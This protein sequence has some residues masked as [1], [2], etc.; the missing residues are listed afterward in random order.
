M[1]KTLNIVVIERTY[2]SIIKATYD[3]TTASI[4]LD[5][6]KLKAFPLRLGTGQVCLLLPL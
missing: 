4:L 2:L 6:E 3:K 1:I 5:N